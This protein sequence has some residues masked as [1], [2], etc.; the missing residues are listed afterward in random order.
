MGNALFLTIEQKPGGAF[1]YRFDARG[2]CVG[3]TWHA[4]IADAKYQASYEFGD[5][6]QSWEEVPQHINDIVRFC[7]SRLMGR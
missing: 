2:E 7:L 6:I 3:D 1:L 4:T 5:G